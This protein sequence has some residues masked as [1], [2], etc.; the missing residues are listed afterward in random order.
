[1]IS[2]FGATFISESLVTGETG[3]RQIVLIRG[4]EDEEIEHIYNL[5]GVDVMHQYNGYVL[6]KTVEKRVSEL[7]KKFDVDRLE[8]RTTL[9]LGEHQFDINEGEPDI[10]EE[11]RIEEYESSE[12][13]QY[14]VHMLGPIAPEWREEIENMGIEVM[15]YIPNYAYRV[16]MTS[17]QARELSNMYFVDWIG[18]YHPDYK[19]QPAI[20]P[21]VVSVSLDP[22]AGTESINRIH[23]TATM[24]SFVDLGERG[25]MGIGEVSSEEDLHELA[26]VKDVDNIQQYV[27][28][29]L[30][31]E[32]ATQ[33]IAGGSYFFDDQDADPETAYRLHG[34]YG[35]YMNQIGYT[36]L[37]HDDVPIVTAIADTGIGDG[38]VGG[39]HVDFQDRV[40]G[41]YSYTTG[42][43]EDGHGHGSHCTGSVGADTYQGTG[44]TYYNDYLSAQGSA[45]D[46]EFFAVRI[47]DG[48]GGYVGPSD[49][50][51]IIQV[52]AQNS[53]AAVHSNSWGA[54]IGGS[55]DQRSSGY[56]EAI[57]DFSMTVT[58][59]A[60]NSGSSYNTIGAPATGKNVITVG[61]TERHPNGPENIAGFSSRGWTDDNRIKPDIVAPGSSIYSTYPTGSGYQTMSGTSMSN[62]A[63]AGASTVTID[64]YEHNHPDNESPSPA[65]VKALLINTANQLGGN[66]EG[67]IPNRDEGWGMVDISKLERPQNDPVPFMLEDQETLL[68]TGDVKEYKVGVN[69]ENEPLKITLTWTDKEAPD[70]TGSGTALMN[71]LNLNIESPSGDVYRGNA[72]QNGWTQPNMNT[73]AEF[74]DSGD[75]WDDTNNVENVYIHPDQLEPG[76]YTIKV[77]GFNVPEDGNNDGDPN[78]DYALAIYNAA[79]GPS[80]NINSPQEGEIIRRSNVP[81]EWTSENF[82][83]NEVR[84]DGSSWIDVGISEQHTFEDVEDGDHTV[85]VRT[86]GEGGESVTDSVNFTVQ[87]VGVEI[88]S[89]GSGDAFAETDVTV[90]WSSEHAEYH[91]IRRNN[92]T[93]E[94]VGLNT[95]Y[96]Y[97]GLESGGHTVDVRATDVE[98]YETTDNVSFIVD[99]TPPNIEIDSPQEG[100]TFNVSQVTVEWRGEDEI[101]GI[102]Y[103]EV[104]L[105][106]ETWENV[107]E[108]ESHLFEGIEDGDH[109]AEVRAT[110]LAGNDEIATVSF[111][112]DTTSPTV[113]ISAPGE[114]DIFNV[115]QV[116]VEWT[117]EDETTSIDHYEVRLEGGAWEEVGKDESHTFE[118]LED[119]D[120]T[121]EVRAI[122]EAGNSEV[123]SVTFTIDTTSPQ[124]NMVDPE[125]DE[126]MNE[127]TV[128]VEWEAT[129]EGTEI[130]LYEVNIDDSGWVNADGERSH[131]FESLVDGDHTVEVRA[132]DEAS[133]SEVTS[134]WF[135]IDMTPPQLNIISPE[136]DST[137]EEETVTVEWEASQEGTEIVSYEVRID[138]GE[139]ISAESESSHTFEGLEDGDHTVEVRAVDQA[140]NENTKSVEFTVD[141]PLMG[142]AGGMGDS[143]C[144]IPLILIVLVIIILVILI[145][146]RKKEEGEEMEEYP[147]QGPGVQG[148]AAGP[149]YSQTQEVEDGRGRAPP[150]SSENAAAPPSPPPPTQQSSPPTPPP[151]PSFEPSSPGGKACPVCG[152]HLKWIEEYESWYC[153]RC[154]EYR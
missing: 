134:V 20:E 146:R 139:W 50:Y 51:D 137:I 141:T 56:D 72:F 113:T 80:I 99:T 127:D 107:G 143:W 58:A 38:N 116:D 132:T 24:L 71:D 112:V 43:W 66:T 53:D 59:S 57:R 110:D 95:S 7:E 138:G 35:S 65:M 103:Y 148:G 42:G 75:G 52:A 26:R 147:Y 37:R 40:I 39:G 78:Q 111:T 128:T 5:Q 63:V 153:D 47:F 126:I 49:T 114:G 45:P 90:E 27:E 12:K 104:R 102:D 17:E 60:G 85:E 83:H 29:E 61:A 16:R 100:D 1:M 117:G 142:I 108:V 28:P 6:V 64:W 8:H 34:D 118:S 77:E 32:I 54:A 19:L 145:A 123:S 55:Y 69:D 89:P 93:W 31:G 124:L 87:T 150:E 84:L 144:W 4:V 140:S 41:G 70:S 10:P 88:I 125:P 101:S 129:P 25:Y 46:T 44:N 135:T 122:D 30:H 154:Q 18:I 96:T 13:G 11:L 33:H 151:P 15:S 119:G 48:G 131:T 109:T 82:D 81:I 130:I 105:E 92:G 86:V 133:N 22:D 121:A 67:A 68:E 23:N 2:V 115:S 91:E 74:D 9:E 152:G 73:M 76:T 94:D 3:E 98:G 21:G 97:T 136:V 14:I 106:G 120:H 149:P 62:P 36:G 79:Q